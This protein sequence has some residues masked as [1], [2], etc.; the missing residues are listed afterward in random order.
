MNT[1]PSQ[2][3]PL[4]SIWGPDDVVSTIRQ[5]H[6][7]NRN[8]TVGEGGVVEF[9]HFTGQGRGG[10]HDAHSFTEPDPGNGPVGFCKGGEVGV[11]LWIKRQE[12]SDEWQ[13]SWTGRH[14]WNIE[15]T[16]AMMRV[17][18]ATKLSPWPDANHR[19]QAS[20]TMA[21][22]GC[23]ITALK[24]SSKDGGSSFDHRNGLS[25]SMRLQS[26]VE[27]EANDVING[28]SV[29]ETS[30]VD[31]VS[32]ADISPDDVV[33]VIGQKQFWKARRAMVNQ[34]RLFG[35]QVFELHR[36]IKEYVF[37][38][39]VTRLKGK[40]LDIFV[41]NSFGSG[42]QALFVLFFLPFLSNLKGI[43]LHEL[44]SYIKSGA[45]CFLN[46]GAMSSGIYIL[47]AGGNRY[48][49]AKL[50]P[51]S[52][53]DDLDLLDRFLAVNPHHRLGCKFLLFVAY[54]IQNTRLLRIV[55]IEAVVVKRMNKRCKQKHKHPLR[56][57]S[58]CTNPPAG[59][60]WKIT[61]VVATIIPITG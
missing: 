9:K 3:P 56:H 61:K 6:A 32:D 44:P 53:S 7:G 27:Q 21:A 45:G 36:L 47:W 50:F 33:G 52:S 34:Q 25:N 38:D 29:S 19:D 12:V 30:M 23:I 10:D 8:V 28:D 22:T 11:K 26:N 48:I 18:V 4:I 41:V 59:P 5:L 1:N 14:W 55:I 42:F 17:L 39:A 24:Q 43:P 31:S 35:V 37:I 54:K 15:N 40:L 20:D 46:I 57:C 58:P 51:L 13:R 60:K 49:L 16:A 2:H